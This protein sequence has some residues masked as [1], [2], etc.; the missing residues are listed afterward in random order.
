MRQFSFH[1][2]LLIER[3]PHDSFTRGI[4]LP[5]AQQDRV[6]YAGVENH[7]VRASVATAIQVLLG[8]SSMWR[9]NSIPG[10]FRFIRLV[11]LP[12]VQEHESLTHKPI[13][14]EGSKRSEIKWPEHTAALDIQ[15]DSALS[16]RRPVFTRR[17]SSHSG[18]LLM[19]AAFGM[20]PSKRFAVR[21]LKIAVF[22][23]RYSAYPGLGLVETAGNVELRQ[24]TR[25]NLCD[26]CFPVHGYGLSG[27]CLMMSTAT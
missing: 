20:Q 13:G 22:A 10:W 11:M 16:P 18:S 5:D 7:Q 3:S 4:R 15:G 6:C 24:A 2:S 14:L 8:A 9:R 19:T 27:S 12:G 21:P 26:E 17:E 25:L 1:T 23:S